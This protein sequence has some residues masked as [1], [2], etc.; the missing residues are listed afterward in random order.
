LILLLSIIIIVIVSI[1]KEWRVFWA[2][3]KTGY[4]AI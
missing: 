3:R 2:G 1:I 4:D